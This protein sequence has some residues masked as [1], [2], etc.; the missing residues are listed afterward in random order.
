MNYRF[1]LVAALALVMYACNESRDNPA[2]ENTAQS[3]ADSTASDDSPYFPV[4]SYLKS[5]IA[6]VDSLPVGIMKYRTSG[7]KQDSSYIKLEEFHQLASEFLAPEL[8][9]SMFRRSF[10]KTSM[11]DQSNS[12]G[13][14]FYNTKDS[15][16]SVKRVDVVT[17]KGAVYDEVKSIYIEKETIAG[18]NAV[19]KK[20]YWKPGRNFQIITLTPDANGKL[21]SEQ[22]KVVWD[23][24]E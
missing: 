2:N 15:A 21:N 20:M 7:A 10:N 5:E 9:D 6:Y 1:I 22:V 23:N 16:T 12:S 8:T 3:T 17:G 19:T 4:T 14:F 11:Y 13:V 24:R 18:T